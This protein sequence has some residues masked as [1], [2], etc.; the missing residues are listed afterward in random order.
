MTS[1]EAFDAIMRGVDESKVLLAEAMFPDVPIDIA[2]ELLEGDDDAVIVDSATT[3]DFDDSCKHKEKKQRHHIP[4]TPKEESHW[5]RRY[6]C[7]SR[8]HQ[9]E[10]A[11]INWKDADPASKRLHGEF[12]TTFRVYWCVFMELVSITIAR[13]FHDPNKKDATQLTSTHL[14]PLD[15]NPTPVQFMRHHLSVVNSSI[16]LHPAS[17]VVTFCSE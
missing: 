2:L 7:P 10:D 16:S 6:L 9:I 15:M 3:T 8:R 13:G 12:F 4:R 5:W 11:E 14:V 17:T 1:A